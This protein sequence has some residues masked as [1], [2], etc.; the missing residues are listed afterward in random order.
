MTIALGVF[1]NRSNQQLKKLKNRMFD[2]VYGI[3]YNIITEGASEMK[4]KE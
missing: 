3:W 1:F 4:Q 2:Y